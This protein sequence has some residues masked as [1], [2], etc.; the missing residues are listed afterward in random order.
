MELQKKQRFSDTNREDLL[1]YLEQG[2]PESGIELTPKQA[3]LLDRYKYADQLIRSGKY[4]RDTVANM[5]IAKCE[6]SRDTAYKDIINAE[7][8][9]SSSYPLN[10]RYL[11]GLRIE[12]L[13]KQIRRA[14]VIKDYMAAAQLEKVLQKY[15][16][17]YPDF[18]PPRAPK[19]IVLNIQNNILNTDMTAEQAFTMAADIAKRL[20]GN[21]DY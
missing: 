21:D 9:F 7:Y 18:L 4:K 19:Q 16:A 1:T 17:D 8:L 11:I 12:L 10:K 14:F 20:E 13:Q 2:G 3:E 6:V 15:I 5:I